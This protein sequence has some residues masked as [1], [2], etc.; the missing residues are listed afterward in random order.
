MSKYLCA[1]DPVE[2]LADPTVDGRG[3]VVE[4]HQRVAAGFAALP[5]ANRVPAHRKNQVGVVGEVRA[6][7]CSVRLQHPRR[8]VSTQRGARVDRGSSPSN[9]EFEHYVHK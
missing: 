3:E 6:S 8:S 7:D 5:N 2:K 1:L 9:A 4:E